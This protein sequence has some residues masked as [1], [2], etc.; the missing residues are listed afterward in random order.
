M[1][2]I[3]IIYRDFLAGSV[4]ICF[5]GFFVM[6]FANVLNKDFTVSYDESLS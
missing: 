6:I 1:Y 4:S 3:Y 2:R 5:R